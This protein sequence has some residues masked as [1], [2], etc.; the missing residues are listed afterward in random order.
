MNDGR[1]RPGAGELSKGR[2]SPSSQPGSKGNSLRLVCS[3]W[4]FFLR[5]YQNHL[6]KRRLVVRLGN[7]PR[8][9]SQLIVLL[10][11]PDSSILR[12]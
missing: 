8:P 11:L 9:G 12:I 4:D 10:E 3:R 7:E 2:P 1:S 5:L 6:G